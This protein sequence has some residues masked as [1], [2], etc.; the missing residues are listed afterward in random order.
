MGIVKVW[1]RA[2]RPALNNLNWPFI[3]S[4]HCSLDQM[5][6]SIEQIVYGKFLSFQTISIRSVCLCLF[7]YFIGCLFSQNNFLDNC[8]ASSHLNGNREIAR[9]S[10]IP[11]FV[12]KPQQVD[13]QFAFIEWKSS[14]GKFELENTR[15]MCIYGMCLSQQWT[16]FQWMRQKYFHNSFWWILNN[17]VEISSHFLNFASLCKSIWTETTVYV[18]K[19]YASSGLDAKMRVFDPHI[20]VDMR[21]DYFPMQI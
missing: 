7:P 4:N 6:N 18:I 20:H 13:F 8:V 10:I 15:P 21:L 2:I 11:A 5:N 3:H 1:Y 16:K 12:F 9:Y 14:I 19:I 17:I